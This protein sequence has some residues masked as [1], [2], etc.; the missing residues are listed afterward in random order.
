MAPFPLR[1][2][3]VR[4]A[5]RDSGW[6]GTVCNRPALTSAC[7]KLKSI[8][9]TKDDTREE[10]LHG[11]AV[12]DLA[13]E[14]LPP[15]VKER[16]TFMAPIAWERFQEHPYGQTSPDTH[17]H[18]APTRLHYPAYDATG[19]PFQW[20]AKK[21]VQEVLQK[22]H[23]LAGIASLKANELDVLREPN[24]EPIFP[25]FWSHIR[26]RP[27]FADRPVGSTEAGLFPESFDEALNLSATILSVEACSQCP[28]QTPETERGVA[29]PE[30]C[31]RSFGRWTNDYSNSSPHLH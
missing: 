22:A 7:M 30:R 14:D 15:C 13:R 17:A 1:H 9:A 31:M 21:E 11:Q 16:A 12:N 25:S 3:T 10:E 29:L 26:S 20:L 24:L 2:L 28:R 18:F 27:T 19:L 6:N 5:W 4:V 23:P 8:D